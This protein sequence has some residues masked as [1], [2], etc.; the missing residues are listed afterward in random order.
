M[1]S[2]LVLESAPGKGCCFSFTLT[3]KLAQ[4][5]D[6]VEKM[7]RKKASN[8]EPANGKSAGKVATEL[9]MKRQLLLPRLIG[10]TAA[11]RILIGANTLHY[12]QCLHS[13]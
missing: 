9:S 5:L 6:Q 1:D 10:H 11:P 4:G 2:K 3:F 7:H 8:S 13:T 12:I